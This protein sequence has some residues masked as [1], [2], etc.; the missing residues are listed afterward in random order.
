MKIGITRIIKDHFGTL[1]DH[2]TG[3]ILV[4]DI[5]LF[6]VTPVVFAAALLLLT[7][8]ATNK[9]WENQ[10]LTFFGIFLALLI[11]VQVALFA[12]LQRGRASPSNAKRSA[13]QE[14]ELELRRTLLGE[15]NATISYL[16][17]VCVVAIAA[18][19]LMSVTGLNVRMTVFI[20]IV[21]YAHFLI[22]MLMVLKRSHAL[23][24]KEYASGQP[25][26]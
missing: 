12:I 20:L 26:E 23:F 17:L 3:R 10:A 5:I 21:L 16:N 4:A 15:I 14:E 6:Y 13:I 19:I 18:S 7:N 22:T 1:R 8:P 24:Q 9:D 25:S 2:A 11:N